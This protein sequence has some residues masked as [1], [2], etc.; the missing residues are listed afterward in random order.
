VFRSF[1]IWSQLMKEHHGSAI[2][3]VKVYED[4]SIDEGRHLMLRVLLVFMDPTKSL[5]STVGAK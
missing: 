2:K 1:D 3:S 5:G 4:R